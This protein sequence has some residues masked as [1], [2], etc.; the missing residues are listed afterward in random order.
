MSKP[1]SSICL[2]SGIVS[3]AMVSLMALAAADGKAPGPPWE[4]LN[5]QNP[6]M[7]PKGE[8]FESA[9]VFNPAVVKKDGKFVMLYRAQ[10]KSGTSRL[11]YASSSD[12]IH[13]IRRS[14]PVLAPETDYERDGG[15]EDPRLVKIGSI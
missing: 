10:D 8:G 5:H 15:V 11:G 4:R 12:G 9:G 2:R 7:A 13:F 1:S 3:I 6:V 14:E